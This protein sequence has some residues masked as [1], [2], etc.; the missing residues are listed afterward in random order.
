MDIKNS[1]MV[2]DISL[3]KAALR[4]NVVGKLIKDDWKVVSIPS[5]FRLIYVKYS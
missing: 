3:A 5:G 1:V 4:F 2:V